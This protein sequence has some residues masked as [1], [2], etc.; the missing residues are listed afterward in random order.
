M[1]IKLEIH[2][3]KNRVSYIAIFEGGENQVLAFIEERKSTHAI[4][5]IK[6]SPIPEECARLLD[7]LY[8]TCEHGLSESLCFGPAHYATYEEIAMGY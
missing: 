1:E 7:R 2:H 5:E 8:P 6:D 4:F 3:C